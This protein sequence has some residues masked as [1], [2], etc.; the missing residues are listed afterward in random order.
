MEAGLVHKGK[1][2]IEEISVMAF[3]MLLHLLSSV[4]T[5]AQALQLGLDYFPPTSYNPT[6]MSSLGTMDRR[7]KE[8][9]R[10]RQKERGRERERKREEEEE[11]Y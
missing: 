10:E 5:A 9:D 3:Q 1:S 2:H 8:R 11:R 7:E 4:S 6:L